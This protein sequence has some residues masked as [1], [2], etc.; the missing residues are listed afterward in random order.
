LKFFSFVFEKLL[1]SRVGK[2]VGGFVNN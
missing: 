1:L 2:V